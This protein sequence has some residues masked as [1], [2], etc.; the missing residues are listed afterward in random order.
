MITED[1]SI[2]TENI[3]VAPA[4]DLYRKKLKTIAVW[5]LVAG[6]VGLIAYIAVSF[7]F[8]MKKGYTP[9]WVDALLIF[10][11]PFALGLIGFI[12]I[13]RLKKREKRE[14]HTGE[15]V[16]YADCF[17]YRYKTASHPEI[18]G[19]KFFYADAVLKRE[20]EQY[21]YI[22]VKSKG[23]LLVFGKAGLNDMEIN[24]VRKLYNLAADG[25]TKEL[26]NYKSEKNN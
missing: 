25:E 26:K 17:F 18:T 22:F 15:F 3:A 9:L 5:A 1:G 20:N 14:N 4:L 8:E 23:L 12:T 19:E 13:V 2:K 10:A 16:F 6:A 7:S 24:T 21:G 11:V